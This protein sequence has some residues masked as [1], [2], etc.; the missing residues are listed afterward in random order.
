M[1]KIIFTLLLLPLFA[2]SQ[3]KIVSG[4]VNDDMGGPLPGATVQVKGSESIG[5]ITDFDGKF[6]IALKA[7]ETTIIVS[8]VG[9][10]SQEIE[11]SNK[12]NIN[13][14]LEQDVSELEEVVVVGYGTVLKSDLTGAV[15][16]VK[17]DD[18]FSRQVNSIDQL[19]QGRAAGVQVTQ[20]AA[21]PNSGVSVRIRGTNSLRGNNEPL[22]VID[23][24]IVSSAAEDVIQV[25]DDQ[26]NTGQDVQSGLNGINP[27]DIES[28]EILKDASATAIYGSRGAN[29]VVLITTKSGSAEDGGTINIFNNVS[30]SSITK[31]YDVL[32]GIGYAEYQNEAAGD[33]ARFFIDGDQVYSYRLDSSGDVTDQVNP[34][35]LKILDWQEEV[36][37]TGIS[38]NTGISFSDGN[39]KGNYYVSA[40]ISDQQGIVK[41]SRFNTFD[42]R[43][44]LN[45]QLNEKVKLEARMSAFTSNSDFSE[46][47]DKIGGDQ[48]FVQQTTT[49]R[50]LLNDNMDINIDDN[51]LGTSNPLTFIDDFS[52]TSVESRIFASLALKYDFNIEGLQYELRFG[53]N[54]RDK[55]RDRFYGT[56][57]WVGSNTNGELQN[58]RLNS[59][60]YQINNLIR[61]NKNFN[62]RHRINA[63]AGVTYDVRDV[64]SSRYAVNDFITAVLGPAQPFLGQSVRAPLFVRAADQ[65]IFSVLGRFNYTFNNKYTLTSTF[66]Y[67]GVS[68]FAPGKQYG[69]FPSFA[70][71]WQ[72]AR[73]TFIKNLNVFSALK[74]RAGW[75]EI[76]NHGIS[77]YGTL[78]SYGPSSSLY[79]NASGGTNVP[80]VLDNIPNPDLTW[81]T[82][83]QLNL[84]IDFGVLRNKITGS[85]DVYD[86]TTKDLL[87]I[88]PT[89]TS[90]GFSELI[91]N[92]GEMSNKGLE[93]SLSAIA[94]DKD[95]FAISFGGNIAFNK[96]KIKNLGLS[97]SDLLVQTQAPSNDNIGE[98]QVQQ[99]PLYF[100]NQVSRG[101]SAKF[102]MN[103]FI[104]G[105][106]SGLFYGWKTDGLYQD[107]DNFYRTSGKSTQA[108]D[109]KVLDLNGDGV[110]DLSDRTVIGNPNPDF[111]Y[112][113]NVNI[114]YK[115]FSLSMLFNGVYGNDIVNAN[116]Y[117]FGW[118]E[119]TPRNI[120]SDA[121]TQRWTPENTDTNYPRLG[122]NSNLYGALMDRVIED[123]S[124]LRLKNV[125]LNY[126]I[127]VDKL[128]FVDA[129]SVT[130]S[131]I[132]L[133][134]WTNYSGYD[135]EVTSFLW[136]GLVQ[137]TDWNNKPNSK[138]FLM[139]LNIKF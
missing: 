49:F 115:R 101:N 83:E 121:W 123:G 96:T 71:N 131:G 27:K 35:P 125:T 119:G 38:N 11:V 80:L 67:D 77:P 8:Y 130:F 13:I 62:N 60:T 48:S 14:S 57:T 87:Q 107:G 139:G 5:S 29:G 90:T 135:P 31:T 1:K 85:V 22:Y 65:Q 102:P 114:D 92:R 137:G 43:I 126:D 91:V 33:N 25:D 2:F 99:R 4:V 89:P 79:G 7:G 78:P 42:L 18:E 124:F 41:S 17:V 82:T 63:T 122:Y 51:D 103:V 138:T 106:E 134:T 55:K 136:D 73:E 94:I 6:T 9:F 120:L 74:F 105:E 24:I 108:G 75:G 19:L 45:Y 129:A 50:P 23:G 34:I 40:G 52:D 64:E 76:G 66:R 56:T 46:G 118:A 88:A 93:V 36:Y 39:E 95:D 110:V 100:G 47:G 20:N 59:L 70:M 15:S 84:G 44:N 97:P 127:N 81:E 16:S 132:N 12:N 133:I 53:G 86:K 61:Y 112:G 117:R 128:N 72:A 68:K 10:V 32:D 58:L 26:G 109:I 113:F 116:M 28:I 104:E 111:T 30:Y 54:L 69:F 21:N 98:Y 3:G 37:K